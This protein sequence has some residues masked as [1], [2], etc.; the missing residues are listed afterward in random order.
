MDFNLQTICHSNLLKELPERTEDVLSRRFGLKGE[1]ETLEEIGAKYDITRER[2][3]QIQDD[4]LRILEK[5]GESP[6][7]QSVFKAFEKNLKNSGSLRREDILLVDLGAG[8]ENYVYFLLTVSKRF[9][10][11]GETE[12]FHTFWA[13]DKNAFEN[14]KKSLNFFI[15]ELQKKRQPMSLPNSCLTS[16]A[17][18]SKKILR[19]PEGLY[20]LKEW[21]E[22]NPR[23]IK[24]K[25]FIVLKKEQKP[26]HFSEVATLIG[27]GALRQTVH[28]ELIKDQRFVLV[29]R[30]LYAL[31]EWGY[32]PGIVR[33]VIA[34]VLKTAKGPMEK[35]MVVDKVLTQRLVKPNTILLNLQNKKYFLKTSEGKYTVREV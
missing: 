4:G 15:A 34:S 25:A 1:R 30:G 29:G 21:P 31:K 7:C 10:R 20:G 19:G 23:G 33:E 18:I 28:N 6:E 12:D 17:E 5:R 16:Y 13:T 26:L 22:I 11:F 3:R 14:A 24:D 35:D 2:V 27:N 32:T 8:K 9:Q